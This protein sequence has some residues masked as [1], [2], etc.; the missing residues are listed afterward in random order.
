MRR[1]MVFGSGYFNVSAVSVST[2]MPGINLG[3][4]PVGIDPT[5]VSPSIQFVKTTAATPRDIRTLVFELL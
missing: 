4:S 3:P 1:Y 5:A 2:P